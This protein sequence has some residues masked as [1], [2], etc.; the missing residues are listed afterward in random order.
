M[1]LNRIVLTGA[2]GMLGRHLGPLLASAG[3][4]VIGSG[5]S[6]PDGAL[7]AEWV[8]WDLRQYQPDS[9]LEECF[10]R[11][12][13][14]VHAGAWV[15]GNLSE[16]GNEKDLLDINVRACMNLGGW[17]LRRNL[18]VVFISS[19]TVYAQQEQGGLTETDPV[20]A[21]GQGGCYGLTK[22]LAEEV[23]AY[24][25]ALGLRVAVLRPSSV[26]GTGMP[27]G[28]M[29]PSFLSRARAGGTIELAPPAN[30]SI[31]F[32]HA[33]DLARAVLDVLERQEWDV[34]NIAADAPTTVIEAAR[35]CVDVSGGGKV[36]ELEAGTATVRQPIR[37]FDFDTSRARRK[38][39]W[40]PAVSLATGLASMLAGSVAMADV[41]EP[42]DGNGGGQ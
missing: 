3:C 40:R 37:R 31:N 6:K 1:V 25:R 12:D 30:D 35:T 29:L 14:I 9:W 38:L 17:A 7:A 22:V 10:G 24:F 34:F 23:F 16:V 26:Y 18:P 2:S 19:G 13:A 5:R 41:T 11:A 20:G 33:T 42:R 39:G 4:R 36:V 32:L 8:E 15:P 27:E 21:S 28:K